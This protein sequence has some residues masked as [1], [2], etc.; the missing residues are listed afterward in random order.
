[1]TPIEAIARFLLIYKNDNEL[2]SAGLLRRLPACRSLI[3]HLNEDFKFS[4]AFS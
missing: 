2:Y 4:L 3:D 1:M